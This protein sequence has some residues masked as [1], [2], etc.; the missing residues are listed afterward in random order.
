M[1]YIILL[2]YLLHFFYSYSSPIQD[3]LYD[4]LERQNEDTSKVNMLLALAEK[5]LNNFPE[6]YFIYSNQ[7]LD[8][9]EKLNY[10]KGLATA[11]NNLG[12]YHYYKS[13]YYKALENYFASL[14]IRKELGGKKALANIYT[15]IGATYNYLANYTNALEFYLKALEIEEEINDKQG[16]ARSYNNIG[17][18]YYINKNYVKTLE[19]YIKSSQIKEAISDSTGLASSYNNIGDL[20][21]IQENY[22]RAIEF[23]TKSLNISNNGDNIRN[24]ANA[25]L[26]IGLTYKDLRNYNLARN[27]LNKSIEYSEKINDNRSLTIALTNIAETYKEEKD[28]KKAKE[29]YNVAL[30]HALKIN[31]FE[32]LK[33]IYYELSNIHEI[34]GDISNALKYHKLYSSA[35]DSIVK[36]S[37]SEKLF[38]LQT[39][40]ETEQKEREIN[41]LKKDKDFKELKL[42]RQ[43]LIINFAIAIL[44]SIVLLT[45]LFFR[46]YRIKRKSNKLLSD[47]TKKLLEQSAKLELAN[48]KLEKL[49]IVARETS[50]AVAIL[51]NNGN[52][53][54]LNDGFSNIY[55][56][57]YDEFIKSKKTK[58]IIELSNNNNIELV[59][60]ECIDN[61]TSVSYE[62]EVYSS[63]NEKLWVQTTLTPIYDENG[64][65]KKIIAVDTDITNIKKAEQEISVKNRNITD[66]INYAKRIQDSILAK[67]EEFNK[68]FTNSFVFFNPKDIVSGD[69]YWI[70]EHENKTILAVA[71]CTGHGVP[72]ALMSLIGIMLLNEIVKQK[73]VLKPS[74]ILNKLNTGV[75]NL[76]HQDGTDSIALDGMDIAI[77]SIDKQEGIVEYSGAMSPVYI[78]DNGK[79][80]VIEPDLRTI[81]GSLWSRKENIDFEYST[82]II[83]IKEN[84]AMYLFTD[85]FLDQFG[86][87]FN[88]KYNS[89]RFRDLITSISNLPARKQKQILS[90]SLSCW[91]G[92]NKQVDDI[93]IIG[94][95]F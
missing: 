58:N 44:V 8:L 26:K 66:S 89:Q 71:D 77:C 74:Q 70:Y 3:S 42:E 17:I 16:M 38:E 81:G 1:K 51:D 33:I 30:T 82:Q 86:G 87:E 6:K 84:M 50:N 65:L 39:Q 28:L 53:E 68:C 93:L 60:K 43:N 79:V 41:L 47:Q 21:R 52:I 27:N 90:E 78:V 12:I 2:F 36:I 5:N 29:L 24:I 57:S 83:E 31:S 85:G 62:S 54:W 35:K 59:L 4:R 20:F 72:G 56:F 49:S 64:L 40:F 22:S 45:F 13:D 32:N 91:K 73:Q 63:K 23:F 10:K 25:Y 75:I 55:G 34:T 94:I 95:N 14:K 92:N 80:S 11:Y 69:F 19:F 76:L 9:S 7:A 37:N 18:I 67:E 46:S 88:A 15:N 61:K 48:L